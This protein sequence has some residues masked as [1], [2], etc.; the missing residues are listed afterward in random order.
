MSNYTT[1]IR[2]ICESLAGYQTSQ[3]F[4]AVQEII[5]KSAPLI[6]DFPWPIY[7]ESHRQELEEKILTYYYTREI[8]MEVFGA[9]KLK[10]MAK[11][12]AIM[13]YYNELYKSV[14]IDFDIFDDVNYTTT[15]DMTRDSTSNDSSTDTRTDNLSESST[16]TDKRT[17]NLTETVDRDVDTNDTMTH[18]M[19]HAGDN[20]VTGTTTDKHTGTDKAL[21]AQDV[22]HSTNS[23][24]TRTPNLSTKDTGDNKFLESDTPQGGLTGLD[25]ND[26]LTN[27]RKE[28]RGTTTTHTGTEKVV[29][30]SSLNDNGTTQTETTYNSTNTVT[31]KN[32]GTDNYEDTGRDT[33]TGTT[34][35]NATRKN[36]GTVDSSS[37]NTRTNTGTVDNEHEGNSHGLQ[38]DNGTVTVKGKMGTTSYMQLI[39]QYRDNILNIDYMIIQ[40]LEPLFMG[41]W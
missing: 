32:D 20:S 15:T 35:D 18:S 33:K 16:G 26:Y 3:D 30:D 7:K 23:T 14:D 21:T 40:E 10:L 17:D 25:N 29:V 24:T 12:Q 39:K 41:I 36:T 2:Y 13:P 6:F 34:T 31:I 27:Y 38:K 28:I 4:S 22:D 8:G 37:K 5:K 9:W 11:L 19:T 1:Q